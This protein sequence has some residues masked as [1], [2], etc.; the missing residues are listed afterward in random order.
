MTAS[1]GVLPDVE[2]SE[3][4]PAGAPPE[5][6]QDHKD[7]SVEE[8]KSTRSSFDTIRLAHH[9]NRQQD[10]DVPAADLES[11]RP[12]STAPQWS[13]FTPPQKRF[14]VFMV[15]LAG[16]FS[17]LS[18]NIYFPA[19]NTLAEDFGTTE[20]VMNLTLT[21]YM[22]FQGFVKWPPPSNLSGLELTINKSL[23][24]YIR[25]SRRHGW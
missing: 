13:I 9:D 21:S 18:A 22:I 16:F 4:N 10:E 15:S 8:Q 23:A 1:I 17:P 14:I 20:S 11:L 7:T 6:A 5:K 12:A 25:R 24:Y 19:L 3:E 2:K